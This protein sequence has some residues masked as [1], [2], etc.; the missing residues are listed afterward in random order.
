MTSPVHLSQF[1]S[2]PS[3]SPP[4]LGRYHHLLGRPLPQELVAPPSAEQEPSR[5]PDR[6]VI[7]YHIFQCLFSP[8]VS[9]GVSNTVLELA[10]NL[11]GDDQAPPPHA[12]ETAASVERVE[13]AAGVSSVGDGVGLVSHFFPTLLV[14]LGQRVKAVGEKTVDSHGQTGLQLEFT[15]LSR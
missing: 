1:P 9:P 15:V 5:S 12:M 13:A 3:P 7:L 6:T 4:P 10:L 8:G 11:L 2:L 14:Y